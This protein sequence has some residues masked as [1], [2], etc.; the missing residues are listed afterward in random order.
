MAFAASAVVLSSC[1]AM[2]DT[3]LD[4]SPDYYVGVGSTGW[5]V[6]VGS[7]WGS[8]WNPAWNNPFWTYPV[9]HPLYRPVYPS[10][11]IVNPLPPTRPG[12]NNWNPP[13][14]RPPRPTP[15]AAPERPTPPSAPNRQGAH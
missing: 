8:P 7:S 12:G 1:D 4:A 11:P 2:W 13:S 14:V 5:N 9:Y 6:G 15:P 3:S 10:R